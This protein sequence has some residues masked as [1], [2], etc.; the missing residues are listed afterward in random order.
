MSVSP[1]PSF[2]STCSLP[3]CHSS[4]SGQNLGA[5]CGRPITAPKDSTSRPVGLRYGRMTCFEQRSIS[6]RE[7]RRSQASRRALAPAATMTDNAQAEAA[8]SAWAVEGGRWNRAMANTQ[9]HF[10]GEMS[11]C[12]PTS[13]ATEN[14]KLKLTQSNLPSF[15]HIP[16][17][18]HRQIFHIR[19]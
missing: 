2:R 6:R 17:L 11:S 4:C 1:K 12:R 3:T 5:T 9:R 16:H 19:L 13:Y 10:V 14:L 15:V 8:A 7:M 18:V